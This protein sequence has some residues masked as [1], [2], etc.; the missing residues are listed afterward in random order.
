MRLARVTRA[1]AASYPRGPYATL[2]ATLR[3][4]CRPAPGPHCHRA[5]VLTRPYAC[6][7]P[8]YH[9]PTTPTSSDVEVGVAYSQEEEM[10]GRLHD[11][12][13]ENS[14][15]SAANLASAAA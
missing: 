14:K 11:A 12:M 1:A 4:R 6:R 15:K 10:T 3:C 9:E 5:Q 13:V 2:P 7:R 8:S